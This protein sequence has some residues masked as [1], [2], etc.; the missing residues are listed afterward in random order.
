MAEPVRRQLVDSSP[1][2]IVWQDVPLYDFNQ[3]VGT[4][5]NLY[6]LLRHENQPVGYL[7]ADNLITGGPPAVISRNCWRYTGFPSASRR[8]DQVG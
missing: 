2:T 3:V 7:V 4:G 6:A 5:W 1:E 8:A